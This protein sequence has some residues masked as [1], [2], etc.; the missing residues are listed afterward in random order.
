MSRENS[1]ADIGGPVV[2]VREGR[3]GQ[4]SADP[5]EPEAS[6]QADEAAKLE[7]P[8]F[9][10][11][12]PHMRVRNEAGRANRF[13]DRGEAGMATGIAKWCMWHGKNA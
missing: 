4:C 13:N 6:I 8:R 7:E 5:A 9:R 12:S 2:D 3:S 11:L 10:P 1:A